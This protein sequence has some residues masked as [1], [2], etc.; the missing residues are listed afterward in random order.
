MGPVLAGT[1]RHS[2]LVVVGLQTGLLG[3]VSESN[4]RR[5]D[6]GSYLQTLAAR[7]NAGVGAL[8]WPFMA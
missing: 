1:C 2:P 7:G 3:R 4:V 8:P 6:D 5:L